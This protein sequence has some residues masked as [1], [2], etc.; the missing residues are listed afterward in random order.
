MLTVCHFCQLLTSSTAVKPTVH[1]LNRRPSPTGYAAQCLASTKAN[2]STE[3]PSSVTTHELLLLH[4]LGC[5]FTSTKKVFFFAFD[6]RVYCLANS[7]GS[8]S[9]RS[10]NIRTN[11]KEKR[12]IEKYHRWWWWR[13]GRKRHT[14]KWIIEHQS[15]WWKSIYGMRLREEESS[16]S[17]SSQVSEVGKRFPSCGFCCGPTNIIR[18]WV[19]DGLCRHQK[20]H[21]WR[22]E[23]NFSLQVGEDFSYTFRFDSKLNFDDNTKFVHFRAR[24]SHKFTSQALWKKPSSRTRKIPRRNL[25]DENS[26]YNWS[27]VKEKNLNTES[28]SEVMIM[29]QALGIV[30]ACA[31]ENVKG[32]KG[33]LR[34]E[35]SS[36]GRQSGKSRARSRLISNS[37]WRCS[38]RQQKVFASRERKKKVS[39]TFL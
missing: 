12:L 30:R 11:A 31:V 38:L 20:H 36:S 3:K 24:T 15:Y 4:R 35:W 32:E 23:W 39:R 5:F 29:K 14:H 1:D 19:I 7:S 16:A 6:I 10:K 22:H 21:P 34:C 27:D 18:N 13:S 33:D 37:L 8:D 9:S 17:A 28:E 2:K 26:N 25:S